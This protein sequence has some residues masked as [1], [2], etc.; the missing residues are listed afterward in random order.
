[1][2]SNTTAEKEFKLELNWLK[3]RPSDVFL[4][5]WKREMDH[6]FTRQEKHFLTTSSQTVWLRATHGSDLVVACDRGF[7][8]ATQLINARA[9][10]YLE[11][12]CQYVSIAP[13]AE[14]SIHVLWTGLLND[15]YWYCLS[16][17]ILVPY[18]SIFFFLLFFYSSI[19]LSFNFLRFIFSFIPPF[20]SPL[21][22]LFNISLLFFFSPKNVLKQLGFLIGGSSPGRGWEFFLHHCVQT[23]SGTHPASYP[24]GTRSSFLGVKRPGREADH[25]PPSCAEVKE[26]VELY[27]HSPS[28]LLW[29]GAQLNQGDNYH[30][31]YL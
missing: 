17:V 27:L 19:H 1:M 14:R 29:H 21:F 12:P 30:I 31:Y 6:R 2:I 4:F 25:S 18:F 13:A 28:T 7:Y 24:V 5:L 22:Y 16:L 20:S 8:H 3:I 11:E 15:D 26:C 23:G 9:F 10:C